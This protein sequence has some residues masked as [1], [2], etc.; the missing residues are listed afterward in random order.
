MNSSSRRK[1]RPASGASLLPLHILVF[2]SGVNGLGLQVMWFRINADRFGSSSLTFLLVLVSFIGGLGLG[3][4]ASKRVAALA[5]RLK[6]LA[7]PLALVGAIEFAIALAALLT[8]A[9]NPSHLGL[10]GAFPYRPDA[11]GFFQPVVG[12]KLEAALAALVMLVPTTLMGTTFP[13]LCHAFRERA[14]LPS[15]LY[16]WNTLGA[17]AGVLAAEF[18]LLPHLGQTFALLCV[19]ACEGLLSIAFFALSRGPLARAPLP[20]APAPVPGRR[21][22]PVLHPSALLMMA[23]LSGLLCGALEVDMFRANRFAGAISD[24]AMSFT[25]LWAVLAIFAASLVVR[26]L[27]R[28]R[29]FVIRFAIPAALIVYAGT[30]LQLHAIRGLFNQ[31]F[32]A[33]AAQHA[34]LH[35]DLARAASIYPLSGSLWL[36][37]GFTGAV[38]FPAYGLISLLLPT[39]CNAAQAGREHIGRAYGLNTLSFCAG[40]ALF[41]W[42]APSVSLFF[43]VK[44]LF[45]VLAAGALFAL[46]FKEREPFSPVAGAIAL[47]LIVLGVVFVPRGFDRRF[48]PPEELPARYPVRAMKSDGASTTYVVEEPH[49]DLLF[50]DSYPMSGTGPMAQRYMRLMAHMPL[51]AQ[52]QPRRALLICFGVGN[53]A[54]AI[55]SHPELSAIDVVDLND[56]VFETAPEFAATNQRAYDDPRVRLIHDDG[57]RFLAKTSERYD[58]VT[59]EPPPPRAAGV[60]RLYSAE[61]YRSVLAHLTPHGMMTQWLPVNVLSSKSANR[62]TATFASVFP[63]A[64]L[65]VGSDEQLILM[66]GRDPFDAALLEHRYGVLA[67]GT[68]EDL[69]RIGIRE[70]LD[71][72]ARIIRV[73]DE[74][75]ADVRGAGI[76]SDQR[77]DLALVMTDPFDPYR[78]TLDESAVLRAFQPSRLEC[79]APLGAILGNPAALRAALPDFPSELLSHP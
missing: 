68:S 59:S 21:L 8:L 63:H 79:G 12:L 47:A 20:T 76:V 40:A 27:G 54:S 31:Q 67:R 32:L 33:W 18:V 28:P 1:S 46:Q 22:T 78:L 17:C 30:W 74:L 57:R 41:S 75:R 3:A 11:R 51:L 29:A 35:P 44:L 62:I 4:L 66:G 56:R 52:D 5:S 19:A 37:L 77:N 72:L 64:L 10:G 58:L 36:L 7:Q 48:F 16:A 50:F 42:A 55:V 69:R 65:F 53:T 25:S 49:G 71:L 6:W 73:D 61:Y 45:V 39:L 9:I 24:A 70:P 26:S 38:V 2:L 13:I 60:Y 43:A 23:S 34:R 14:T 15:E